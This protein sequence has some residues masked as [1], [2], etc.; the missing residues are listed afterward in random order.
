MR[1]G[2]VIYDIGS[3]L[4]RSENRAPSGMFPFVRSASFTLQ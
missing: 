2:R 1:L 4:D 3:I